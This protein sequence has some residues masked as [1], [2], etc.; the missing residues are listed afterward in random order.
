[1]HRENGGLNP[2]GL[3]KVGP[4]ANAVLMGGDMNYFSQTLT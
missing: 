1:M 3:S 2:K 4:N